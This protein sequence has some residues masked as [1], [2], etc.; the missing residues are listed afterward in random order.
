[1][2]G[3]QRQIIAIARALHFNARILIMDEPT[4]ALGPEETKN[5][6]LLIK[7]VKRQG[8]GIFSDQPRHVRCFRTIGPDYS[9]EVR[10]CGWVISDAGFDLRRS[11]NDHP[12]SAESRRD[13]R[14]LRHKAKTKVERK[15]K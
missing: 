13:L 11:R 14:P 8:L 2:S 10:W 3:G 4:A 5:V 1:M 7:E 12:S 9:D 6:G 15:R